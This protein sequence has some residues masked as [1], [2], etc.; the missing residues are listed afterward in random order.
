LFVSTF[1]EVKTEEVDI[2]GELLDLDNVGQCYPVGLTLRQLF[3]P[4]EV[5]GRIVLLMKLSLI[6]VVVL[7]EH[8]AYR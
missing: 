3:F 7:E 2:V 4:V 8:F 1:E 6:Q 5:T